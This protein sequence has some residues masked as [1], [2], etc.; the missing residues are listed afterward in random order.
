MCILTTGSEIA[1]KSPGAARAAPWAMPNA[2]VSPAPCRACRRVRVVTPPF[3]DDTFLD[4]SSVSPPSSSRTLAQARHVLIIRPGGQAVVRRPLARAAAAAGA[5]PTTAA[6]LMALVSGCCCCCCSHEVCCDIFV[7]VR[8]ATARRGR[9]GA[10]AMM[11]DGR[12]HTM[13]LHAVGG[14]GTHWYRF[15]H[16]QKNVQ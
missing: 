15:A 14:D 12:L 7:R 2:A 11:E 10:C 9:G 5:R 8:E 4:P 1:G 6:I 16:V 13:D 3:D